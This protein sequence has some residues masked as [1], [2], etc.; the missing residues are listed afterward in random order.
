MFSKLKL[1]LQ[2]HD[3][4]GVN[5]HVRLTPALA[6]ADPFMSRTPKDW[7]LGRAWDGDVLLNDE[8]GICGPAAA[9]NWLK[10]MAQASRQNLLFDAADALAAYR[11][12]GYD[13]TPETDNGVVLLDFMQWWTEHEIGGFKL[14]CFFVIGHGDPAHLATALQIAP[15]IVGASLSN[16]CQTSDTW[17]SEAA[18][19]PSMW[20]RHAYLY[21]SDSPGGGNGKS[22]GEPVFST[23]EF[24]NAKWRECYLPICRELMPPGT[25]VLRL[26]NIAQ[27]L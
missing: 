24:R 8:L 21:H 11:A 19:D 23:P 13:G 16:T 6:G 10:M 9:V 3:P 7:A 14:D 15:V 25:D 18:A 2:P 1:G 4:R 20:G 26:L 5:A 17:G 27:S 22:W 12:L